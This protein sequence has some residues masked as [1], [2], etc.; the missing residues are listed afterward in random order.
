MTCKDS[1]RGTGTSKDSRGG[2]GIGKDSRRGAE[3]QRERSCCSNSSHVFQEIYNIN[4]RYVGINGKI[5][6]NNSAL[7]ASLRLCERFSKEFL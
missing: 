1:R 2:A 3:A 6:N 4:Q 5:S 7:S